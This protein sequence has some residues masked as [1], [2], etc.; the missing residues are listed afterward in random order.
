M[1]VFVQCFAAI[2]LSACAVGP[3]TFTTNAGSGAASRV[4]PQAL[5]PTALVIAEQGATYGEG[6]IEIFQAPFKTPS[7]RLRTHSPK[8]A[9]IAPNGD[10][11]VFDEND[12]LW[13]FEPP[14]TAKPK[15]ISTEEYPTGQLLFDSKNRLFAVGYGGSVSVFNP[16]YTSGLAF[17]FSVGPE[18]GEV[19]FDSHYNLFA[20]AA[21]TTIYECRASKHYKCKVVLNTNGGVA[22][23]GANDLFTS[24]NARHYDSLA[25]LPPPYHKAI[26]QT[27]V[28]FRLDAIVATLRGPILASGYDDQN[29]IHLAVFLSTIKGKM[30]QLPIEQYSDPLLAFTILK[31][32]GNLFISAGDYQRPCVDIYRYPYNKKPVRCV[33][34]KYPITA[35]YA[36]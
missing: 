20:S 32:R 24:P 28:G 35:I 17:T 4:A 10:L 1:R 27:N 23:N 2:V 16:P 36:Q 11:I 8:G 5:S 26:A 33:T 25:Q 7:T 21:G 14:F 31:N 15:Q 6:L 13:V 34:A 18:L 29:T 22:L 12:G 19:A 9:V 3:A 30:L